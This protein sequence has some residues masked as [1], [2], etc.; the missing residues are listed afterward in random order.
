MKSK[1]ILLLSELAL[2]IASVF[3]FRSLW[4]LLDA[5][6]FMHKPAALWLSLLGGTAITVWALGCMFKHGGK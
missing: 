6:E 4:M 3:V 1:R 5:L 2:I